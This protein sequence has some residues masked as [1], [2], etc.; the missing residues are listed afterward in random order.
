MDCIDWLLDSDPAIRW[1]VMRDL[2]DAG[3]AAVAAERERVS[4][5]GLGR[6]ILDAQ[7]PDGAWRREGVPA[8]LSTLFTLL[9]RSTGVDPGDPAVAAVLALPAE[10][11][12]WNDNTGCWDL[13]AAETG[14]NPFFEG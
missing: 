8:W 1:Q 11:L 13:R 4:R 7:Q 3:S 12:R 10:K 9:L 5:E 14:G 6:A 2:T